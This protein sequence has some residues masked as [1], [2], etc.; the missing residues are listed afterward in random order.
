MRS[1]AAS[2]SYRDFL[3]MKRADEDSLVADA[4]KRLAAK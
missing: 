4:R 1:S 2:E 3:A